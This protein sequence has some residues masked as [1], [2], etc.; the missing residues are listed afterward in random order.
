MNSTYTAN[1]YINCFRQLAAIINQAMDIAATYTWDDEELKQ[2]TLSRI[3]ESVETIA[4]LRGDSGIFHA[5][6]PEGLLDFQSEM[7][8][9]EDT[10]RARLLGLGYRYPQR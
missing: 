8:R 10:L 6:R 1:E 9:T 2:R 3:A 7:Y 5:A 4:S